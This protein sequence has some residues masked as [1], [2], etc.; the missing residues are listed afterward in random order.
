[1]AAPIPKDKVLEDIQRVARELGHA[2]TVSEY[3]E[4]GAYSRPAVARHFDGSFVQAREVSGVGEGE[5][6]PNSREDLLDDIQRVADVVG[7]E[8]SKDDYHDHG[9]YALSGITYRFGTWIDAKKEAGAYDGGIKSFKDITERALKEDIQ[10]VADAVDGGLSREEYDKWGEF[11]SK[12]VTRRLGDWKTA[13]R[14][15]GVQPPVHGPKN[16]TDDEILE[17]IQRVK[18]G[19]GYYPPKSTYNNQGEFSEGIVK[20]RFGSWMSALVKA[21]FEGNPQDGQRNP[22]WSD[23]PKY[24]SYTHPR[25]KENRPKALKRDNYQCQ[26][27]GCEMTQE[28]HFDEFGNDLTM[29]HINRDHWPGNPADFHSLDNLVTVCKRHHRVWE[30]LDQH[31][32]NYEVDRLVLPAHAVARQVAALANHRHSTYQSADK[33]S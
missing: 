32:K 27:P 6:R 17:D 8:P 3:R 14:E 19:I 31:P 12:S 2:P 13:L 28:E 20:I 26:H 1:M 21:G 23:D 9:E 24:V 4:H 10:R 7:G 18:E 11:S 30:G 22:N 5:I 33:Y 29:H 15:I 16:A 25:W